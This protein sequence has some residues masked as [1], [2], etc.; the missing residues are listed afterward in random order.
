MWSK[1][2]CFLPHS[3]VSLWY[4]TASSL[5]TLVFISFTGHAVSFTG[6]VTS[7]QTTIKI[8]KLALVRYDH[9]IL[10]SL[11][12]SSLTDCFS[13]VLYGK[14]VQSESC[15]VFRCHLSG[16]LQSGTSLHFFLDF[17]NLGTF[18]YYRLVLYKILILSFVWYFF[19]IRF[20]LCIFD[21]DVTEVML[22]AYC[23]LSWVS[24]FG[25][26]FFCWCDHWISGICQ[27]SPQ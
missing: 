12:H 14:M 4:D 18:E 23:I 6:H 21:R 10:R 7:L 22:C 25:T 9:L 26:S 19:V 3:F 1:K 20:R 17:Y 16:L 8:R 13:N 24:N 15:V 2:D 27:S 5:S 11:L